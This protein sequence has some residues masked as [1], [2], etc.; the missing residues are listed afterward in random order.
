MDALV[1]KVAVDTPLSHLDRRFDYAIPEKFRDLAKPGV[2][3]R[4]RFAGK[5]RDGWILEVGASSDRGELLELHQVSSGEQVL[6]PQVAQAIREVADH[7]AG[8]FADVARLAVPPR[9]LATER[10]TPPEYPAPAL[11]GDEDG[12]YLAAFPN[13]PSGERYLAALRSGGRP[14]AAWTLVPVDAMVGDWI[15]GFTAAA[16]ATLLSGRGVLLLV[17][18]QAELDALAAACAARFGKGSFVQLNADAGPAARYRRFL[19]AS[20]SQVK[21]VL[22]TR[23]AVFTPVADL[24]LI[25]LW[26]DG[27]DLYAEP[28]APYPHA[29]EVAAIR[30]HLEGAGV[31]FAAYSRTAEVQQLLEKGWLRPIEL[32]PKQIRE[33]APSVVIAEGGTRVPSLV[34]QTIRTALPQGPVLVQVRADSRQVA[35][36]M[37]KA[38]PGVAVSYSSGDHRL[39]QV[40]DCGQIVLST[41]GAEPA[42]SRGYAAGVLLDAD[43]MAWRPELRSAEEA[44]R[45]WLAVVALVRPGAEGGRVAVAGDPSD[46]AIQALARLDAAGFGARELADRAAAGFPPAAKLVHL[47]GDYGPLAAALAQLDLPVGAQ[48]LGPLPTTEPGLFRVSLR[49]PLQDGAALTRGVKLVISRRTAHKQ[50]PIRVRVDPQVVG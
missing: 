42:A 3:V 21:L 33:A 39:S 6:A 10:A 49:A 41:P 50:P 30:A 40:P 36:E 45:R 37:G 1:A 18:G 13:Y 32:P 12:R 46:R 44:L 11:P 4:V 34:F 47:E 7:Y 20:R 22:G 9:H 19:A 28:R 2:R 15:S 43:R 16:E 23:S 48:A 5:L 27:D 17:P 8:G 25:G 38:F 14:R 26:D 31:L 35:A 29:R 24:G